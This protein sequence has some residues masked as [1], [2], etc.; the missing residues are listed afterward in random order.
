MY[1]EKYGENFEKSRLV[2]HVYYKGLRVSNYSKK[3]LLSTI[4]K[5]VGVPR[6]I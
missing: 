5:F 6:P 4:Q 1:R 3:G 2:R